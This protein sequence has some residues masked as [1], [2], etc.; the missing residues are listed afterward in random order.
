[1]KSTYQFNRPRPIVASA[2]AHIFL[3][4]PS[5]SAG[6][7]P[8]VD[9]T[10][11]LKQERDRLIALSDAVRSSGSVAPAN[12]CCVEVEKRRGDKTYCYARL[13]S[14]SKGL[15]RWLGR[16]SS[17]LH[18]D[19]LARIERREAIREIEQQSRMV[20]ALIDRQLARP[21]AFQTEEANSSHSRTFYPANFPT[22]EQTNEVAK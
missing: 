22:L 12:C 10:H 4:Q 5:Q 2:E 14:D 3:T 21:I 6:S 18:K 1:M 7:E 13:L 16:R 15:R 17:E 9:Q 8:A 19:W 20:S 11:Y